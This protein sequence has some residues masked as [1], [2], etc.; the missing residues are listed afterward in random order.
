M[1][2]RERC[3]ATRHSRF[4]QSLLPLVEVASRFA[5]HKS[6][7]DQDLSIASHPK[8]NLEQSSCCC[9]VCETFLKFKAHRRILSSYPGHI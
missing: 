7:L 5:L 2:W 8:L 4:W 9:S 1:L 3:R 6:Y